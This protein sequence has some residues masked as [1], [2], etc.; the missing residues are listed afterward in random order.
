MAVRRASRRPPV[1][2]T[3]VV[4]DSG[5]EPDLAHHLDVV[6]R[7]HPQPL[8]LQQLA[9]AL[10]LGQPLGELGLDAVDRPLHPLGA[11]HVVRGGEDGQLLVFRPGDAVTVR[12]ATEGARLLLL[13]GEH[14]DGPRHIWWNF[15]SSRPD[16][17]EAAKEDWRAGRFAGV[18]GESEFIP[19]PDR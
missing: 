10:Q 4:L 1:D 12:A 5:A 7:A 19:L 14:M 11:G 18:P 3:R 13:G 8:G 16:R 2:V 6:R 17:I 15:V 9:L